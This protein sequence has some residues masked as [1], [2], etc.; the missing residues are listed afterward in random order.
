MLFFFLFF[1]FDDVDDSNNDRAKNDVC[2]K[3]KQEVA[4]NQAEDHV[5]QGV[6]KAHAESPSLDRFE[7]EEETTEQKDACVYQRTY[8]RR[9]D[10][11][12]VAV[13][14][15]QKLV[16]ESRS[17]TARSALHKHRYDRSGDADGKK[18]TGVGE[19]YDHTEDK[20]EPRADLRPANCRT[21]DDRDQYQ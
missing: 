1:L 20:S 18:R 9:R 7:E 14:F 11:C 17:Q 13:L 12:N 2:G 15:L 8:D 6:V 4:A 3:L 19:Q 5:L 21:D 16:N 10:D